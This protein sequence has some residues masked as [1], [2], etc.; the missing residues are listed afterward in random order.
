MREKVLVVA[1]VLAAMIAVAGSS[2]RAAG[3]LSVH[4]LSDRADLISG[5]E[6]LTAVTLPHGV[7]P[8]SVTVTLNGAP[9]TGEFAM[10]PN[11]SFEGLVTGLQPGSNVLSVQAPGAASGQATIIDHAIGGPVIAGPQVQPWVCGNAGATDAQCDAP[12]TY[13]YEYKS[14]V[15]GA[16][17]PYEPGKPPPDVASTTTDNGQTVPFIIRIET[18]YQDRDQYQIAV[19]FQPGKPWEPWAPQPQFD[20]KLLITHGASCGIE[21]KSGTAPSVTSDTVGV[22]G[23]EAQTDSPTTALGLGFAVMSTALDNAGHNCNLAT[24]AESLIMA[25]EHLIDHYGTLRYAIGTGCSGGSLVQ[26]QVANAYPGIYQGILP[27]CSFQ[28]SWSNAEEISD[29]HQ[30]RKYFEHPEGWGTGIAWTYNQIAAV[31]GHPNYGNPIIFDTVYWE[32]LANPTKAC[33]GVT[34]AE[35]YN[36]ETNPGGVRCTLADYMV[37]VFGPRPESAWGPVEH[38]LGHGFAGRPVGNAGVQYGLHALEEGIITPAQFVDLNAKVGGADIDLKATKERIRADEPAVKYAY[39]SGS[40]NEANN[41]AGVPIIDLRG[42]DPGA[43][44]DAYRTWSMRARLERDEGHFPKNHVIWFGPAP[45]IGSPKYTT[46]GLLAMDRWLSAVEA[47]GRKMSLTE[48]VAADRPEDVHDKCSNVAVVEEASVPGVGPVCQLPLA[49]TRFATPR[50]V[51]GE[52]IATDVQECRLKPLTQSAYYPATFTAEQWT[53]LRQAFP[54]GVCD[55]SKP[56]VS[57]QYTIPWRTYQNDAAGGAV[58]YGGKTLG[59]APAG[60][61]EGWTG[62]PFAGWLK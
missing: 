48:K 3:G 9:V 37:N 50:V 11:G 28:D 4:V 60:S 33:P 22:P 15:T 38:K 17:L 32:E 39:L 29:Y 13:S 19:L 58:L 52:S 27:Q 18:G 54:A 23:V 21:H 2:A 16:M 1:A 25:K 35:A 40:V 36:P 62:A 14:S 53:Q 45:L 10:R 43:F 42:P 26:Q 56:G 24:Q 8:A 12:T 55:F 61:G 46:E 57:Q 20:H 59:K 47:D 6:A 41:L 5:G 44:H 7:K 30:T 31:E 49:E 34:S 51:A